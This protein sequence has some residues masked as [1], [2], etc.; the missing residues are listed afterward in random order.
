MPTWA[1]RLPMTNAYFL[2]VLREFGTT[3][4]ARAVILDG[5]DPRATVAGGEIAL[6]DQLRQVRNVNCC[7]ATGWALRIASRFEAAVHGPVAFA[8]VSAPTLGDSIGV[9]ARYGY[10]RSPFYRSE[11]E[12]RGDTFLLRVLETIELDDDVRR[13]LLEALLLSIESLIETVFGAPMRQAEVRIAMRPPP[14]A[15][16]YD[17]AFHAPVRFDV[18]RTEIALPAHWLAIPSPLADPVT[19]AEALR[20][21]E[22]LAARLDGDAFV[23]ARVEQLLRA[24]PDGDVTMEDV[25]RALGMS[26]RTLAR[27]LQDAG[28]SYRDVVENHLRERAAALL[29]NPTLT[30]AE[31]AYRLGYEDPANFGRAF[32]RWFSVSPGQFRKDRGGS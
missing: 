2:L 11:T 31:V 8:S 18:P 27:K 10:V 32:R 17:A 20:T 15:E 3:P 13:P 26:A 16:Q 21:L 24:R 7:A 25:A 1:D 29:A 14:H 22:S 19:H 28:T 23:A 9:V 4:E 12:R 30:I 6:G 5:I